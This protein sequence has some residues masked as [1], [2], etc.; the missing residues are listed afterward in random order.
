MAKR[1]SAS[2]LRENIY[3]IL[4]EV[5]ETG[6]PVEIT[7]K[8]VILKIVPPE[9]VSRLSLL[10]KRNILKVP[11]EGIIHLNWEKEWKP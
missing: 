4:D 2:K 5:K 9:K 8:G 11:P 7:R 6:Q 1:L 3:R 10:K